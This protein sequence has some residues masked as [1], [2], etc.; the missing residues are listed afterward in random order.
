LAA[1]T[2]AANV[3]PIIESLRAS[4]VRDLRGLAAAMN[5]R[6]VRTPVA[7][8]ARVERE[9]RD[10]PIAGLMPFLGGKNHAFSRGTFFESELGIDVI[11]IRLMAVTMLGGSSASS[12]SISR[13]R[14]GCETHM[15]VALVAATF[16]VV[17]LELMAHANAEGVTS[18]DPIRVI[19]R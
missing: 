8:M 16:A 4:G 3:L 1:A 12:A 6:G 17:T 18:T 7:T 13:A 15:L 19:E 10:R 5:N 14:R 11:V 2:F 9:E